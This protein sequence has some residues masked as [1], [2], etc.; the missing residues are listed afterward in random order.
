MFKI[1]CAFLASVTAMS[2]AFAV[3]LESATDQQILNELAYRLRTGGGSP[4]QAA[5]Q[6]FTCAGPNNHTLYI[7][8]LSADAVET[9][10]AIVI[11]Y[12][13]SGVAQTLTSKF[14]SISKVRTM[15]VCGGAN[16]H[17][18]FKYVVTPTVLK[19]P[20]QLV[21][22]HSCETEAAKINAQ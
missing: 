17:T 1:V 22:G 2:S 18:L 11:G 16:R 15:A 12:S 10:K 19:D 9:V 6:T 4:S 20:T 7:S 3:E 8:H 14:D 21:I 13:C 5:Q